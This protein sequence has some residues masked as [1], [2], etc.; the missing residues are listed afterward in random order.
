[1]LV[2]PFLALSLAFHLA[3]LLGLQLLPTSQERGQE[4][5][6]EVVWKEKSNINFK[7]EKPF[8]SHLVIPENILT[9]SSAPADFSSKERQ[10]VLIET[11]ALKLGLNEN[12]KASPRFL[13][14]FQ[15]EKKSVKN[16]RFENYQEGLPVFEARQEL[17]NLNRG[18]STVSIPLPDSMAVGSFTALN[19]D[20]NLYYSFYSRIERQIYFRWANIVDRAYLSFTDDQRRRLHR[21]GFLKT[22]LVILLNPKG[23]FHRAEIH[24]ASGVQKID[25]SPALA[26]QE[27]RVFPNPPPEM[28]REDG[29][30]H[31]NYQFIVDFRRVQ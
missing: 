20:R 2:K 10:R 25:I 17:N 7:N 8:I 26:F 31:L 27:A 22:N 16:N 9:E 5:P 14:P 18:E 3:L 29:F 28:V 12:R 21:T 24:A 6:I 23:E 19:T 11:R 13:E 15:D 30:I 4:V 1:M